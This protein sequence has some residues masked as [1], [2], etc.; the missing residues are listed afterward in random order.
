MGAGL[1]T[2]FL[3]PKKAFQAQHLLWIKCK[4]V[5]A[6]VQVQEQLRTIKNI[7]M[8]EVPDLCII[9]ACVLC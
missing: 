5:V 9:P 4:H 3:K 7:F 6:K 2:G 8:N 1:Q